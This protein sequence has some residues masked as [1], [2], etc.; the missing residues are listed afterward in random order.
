MKKGRKSKLF[1]GQRAQ[2]IIL[3]KENIFWTIN[4]KVKR[5]NAVHS[6][7]IKL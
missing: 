5:K 4:E 3:H 1:E 6:V 7:I 2:N